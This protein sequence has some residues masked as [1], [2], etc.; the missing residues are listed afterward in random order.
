MPSRTWHLATMSTSSQRTSTSF[1]FPSSPHCVPTIALL[2]NKDRSKLTNDGDTSRRQWYSAVV[3]LFATELK[4]L[5]WKNQ[6]E[7]EIWR[8]NRTQN[9]LG[10]LAS[11]IGRGVKDHFGFQRVTFLF[12]EPTFNFCIALSMFLNRLRSFVFLSAILDYDL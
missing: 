4:S 12:V 5:Q 2:E 11:E 7:W 8:N 1:P 3:H 10:F 6:N 9:G